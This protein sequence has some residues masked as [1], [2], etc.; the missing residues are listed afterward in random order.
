MTDTRY[1]PGPGWKRAGIAPVYDH[2]SGIRVHVH[3]WLRLACGKLID[4][5]RWPELLSVG[6]FVRICGGNRKRGV[7]VWGRYTAA[8]A[9]KDGER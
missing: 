8:Q 3:G 6:R 7:M 2:T 9:A 4:G 5:S 1:R